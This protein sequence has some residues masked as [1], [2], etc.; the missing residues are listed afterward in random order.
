MGYDEHSR[1]H[2]PSGDQHHPV[3]NAA[4]LALK[5]TF[6]VVGFPPGSPRHR[7]GQG[8][9]AGHR[10][11]VRDRSRA[12]HAGVERAPISRARPRS[13]MHDGAIYVHTP[14]ADLYKLKATDGTTVWGPVQDLRQRAG[15]RRHVVADRGGRQGDGRPLGRAGRDRHGRARSWPLAWPRAAACSRPTARPGRWPGAT[16]RCLACRARTARW[17]G[18]AW[19]WMWPP[20]PSTRRR[21]TTGTWRARTRTRSTRSSLAPAHS[22]GRSRYA[23]ATCG[24]YGRGRGQDTDFGAESDPGRGRGRKIIAGGD[25]GAA[26]WALIPMT[27]EI[28]WKR[29]NLSMALHPATGGI[30]NNGAFDGTR[31]STWCRTSR[32]WARTSMRSTR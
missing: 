32:R 14:A 24:A 21:A 17:S 5:W 22:C 12:R 28:L 7:R 4:T 31:T 20:A 30:L 1:Y 6:P 27:G 10:R 15:R 19:W 26:F 29:E 8:V 13:R 23:R 25:K 3:Q 9:R 16:T 11:H 18:R 2:N